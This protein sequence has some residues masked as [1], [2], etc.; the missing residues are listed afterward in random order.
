[1]LD[2]YIRWKELNSIPPPGFWLCLRAEIKIE[3]F[4][5]NKF[6]VSG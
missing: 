2:L 5:L 6:Q 3:G 4:R 1:M